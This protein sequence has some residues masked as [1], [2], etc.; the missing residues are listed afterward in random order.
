MGR[1]SMIP[2]L[3]RKEGQQTSYSLGVPAT[4]RIVNYRGMGKT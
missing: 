3:I 1:D 4:Y 2:T